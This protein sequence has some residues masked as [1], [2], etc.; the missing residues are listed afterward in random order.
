MDTTVTNLRKSGNIQS[1]FT[2]TKM[3]FMSQ[4]QEIGI[5][6]DVKMSKKLIE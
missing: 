4:V 5:E 2:N 6:L 3:Q 1:S